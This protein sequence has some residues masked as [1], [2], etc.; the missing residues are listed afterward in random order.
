MRLF[1]NM[2][3]YRKLQFQLFEIYEILQ[4][5]AEITVSCL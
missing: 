3:P 4:E 2:A 5:L 1:N